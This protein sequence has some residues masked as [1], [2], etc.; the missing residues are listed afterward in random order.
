M[1][2]PKIEKKTWFCGFKA[3][4]IRFL[5]DFLTVKAMVTPF[6]Q[7]WSDHQ[8]SWLSILWRPNLEA[9]WCTE[10][11]FWM[12]WR[13][14]ETTLLPPNLAFFMIS[15]CL[16]AMVTLLALIWSD[17]QPKL[18]SRLVVANPGGH[19]IAPNYS[20]NGLESPR[21]IKLASK[22][23]IFLNISRFTIYGDLVQFHIKC[24]FFWLELFSLVYFRQIT[25][26]SLLITPKNEP[27]FGFVPLNRQFL[28]IVI[29]VHKKTWW[30]VF[31]QYLHQIFTTFKK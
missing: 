17:D 21:K 16:T 15:L 6:G 14:S 25:S 20:P 28:V 3:L 19:L 29:H 2:T 31:R 12:V 7:I 13:A 27:N 23:G 22:S 9:T 24:W 5:I 11:T 26:W 10:T 30:F 4:K 8:L 1:I 18:A